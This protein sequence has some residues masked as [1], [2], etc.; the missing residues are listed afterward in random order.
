MFGLDLLTSPVVYIPQRTDRFLVIVLSPRDLLWC[1]NH[2]VGHLSETEAQAAT[3]ALPACGRPMS[4]CW[5]K[6]FNS[7]KSFLQFHGVD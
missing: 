4:N 1:R 5:A 3:D 7:P 2:R 6:G